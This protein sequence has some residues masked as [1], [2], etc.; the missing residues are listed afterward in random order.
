MLPGRLRLQSQ[1]TPEAGRILDLSTR[2]RAG[3][4]RGRRGAAPVASTP[5]ED[6]IPDLP[7]EQPNASAI[8]QFQF[9]SADL[10]SGGASYHSV[11]SLDS[12]FVA[13]VPP[14]AYR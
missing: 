4:G 14:T 8:N 1:E 13:P 11:S 12:V 7:W 6:D 10:A 5:T 9:P 2:S 3:R